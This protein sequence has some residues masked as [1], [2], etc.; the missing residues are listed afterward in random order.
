MPCFFA[1]SYISLVTVTVVYV[2]SLG[3]TP[4]DLLLLRNLTRSKYWCNPSKIGS[5]GSERL[6]QDGA[7]GGIFSDHSHLN[8]RR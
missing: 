4:A 1:T 5:I 2:C 6:S 8:P 3:M 7:P